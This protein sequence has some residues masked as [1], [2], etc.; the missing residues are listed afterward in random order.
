MVACEYSDP[1]EDL[2]DIA[3]ELI[4]ILKFLLCLARLVN[5]RSRHLFL[6]S[7]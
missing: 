2:N 5:T 4:K 7:F 6:H 1:E 3:L